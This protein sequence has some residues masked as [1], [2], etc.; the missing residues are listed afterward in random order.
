VGA[1]R[2]IRSDEHERLAWHEIE[3]PPGDTAP[4]GEEVAAFRSVDGQFAVGLWRRA[5][6][7]GPMVLDDYHEVALILEGDV[8]VT[9][10]GGTV[11]RAGPGDLLITPR[12]T[13]ATWRSLSPVKKVWAIYWADSPG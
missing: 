10:E 9:D 8:E 11:H 12:G 13:R 2:V 5:P 6:E 1:I 4:P 3:R 7:E